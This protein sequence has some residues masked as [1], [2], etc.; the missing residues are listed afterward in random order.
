MKR[1]IV[2]DSSLALDEETIKNNNIF[3]VESSLTLNYKTTL[4]SELE[5]IEDLIDRLF[6]VN[7]FTDPISIDNPNTITF[8][9]AYEKAIAAGFEEIIVLSPCSTVVPFFGNA[10]LAKKFVTDKV[11]IKVINSEHI[12][13][14]YTL[15]LDKLIELIN[16]VETVEEIE[17]QIKAFAET[18]IFYTVLYNPTR[19]MEEKFINKHD[20]IFKMIAGDQIIPRVLVKMENRVLKVKSITKTLE[21]LY[22]NM[23]LLVN[24]ENCDFYGSIGYVD[25]VDQVKSAVKFFKSKCTK[26]EFKYSIKYSPI[27]R[28]RMGRKAIGFALAKK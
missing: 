16:K 10:I 7:E 3:V 2:V 22:E 1:A 6:S 21:S 25:D 19:A 5:N 24:E 23:G 4:E 27:T 9:Q 12:L 26:V 17:E 20:K 28:L 14:A 11:R 13:N 8:V 18:V 15:V